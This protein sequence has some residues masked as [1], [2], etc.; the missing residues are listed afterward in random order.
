MNKNMLEYS[1]E[2]LRRLNKIFE[3]NISYVY[4]LVILKDEKTNFYSVNLAIDIEN[5]F[6]KSKN[7]IRFFT[8]KQFENLSKEKQYEALGGSVYNATLGGK[9]ANEFTLEELEKDF[10]QI[11]DFNF[12]RSEDEDEE[13]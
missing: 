11:C 8:C 5:D 12:L 7:R 6:M 9:R 13:R 10:K 3:D 4:K 2:F 1:K